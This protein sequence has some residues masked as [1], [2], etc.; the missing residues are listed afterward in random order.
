VPLAGR[1]HSCHA[2]LEVEEQHAMPPAAVQVDRSGKQLEDRL[3]ALPIPDH[4]VALEIEDAH[5]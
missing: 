1:A 3:V 2:A 4:L 5:A